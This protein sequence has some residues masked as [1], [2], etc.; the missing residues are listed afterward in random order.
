MCKHCNSHL[1]IVATARLTSWSTVAPDQSAQIFTP[2]Y[3]RSTM[4]HVTAHGHVLTNDVRMTTE[5]IC[6]AWRMPT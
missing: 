2:L 5:F 3:D 1:F 4:M 6:A